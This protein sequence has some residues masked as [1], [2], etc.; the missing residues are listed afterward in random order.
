MIYIISGSK[1]YADEF[2]YP[3]LSVFDED[4]MKEYTTLWEKVQDTRKDLNESEEWYFGT[5]EGFYWSLNEVNDI[6]QNASTVTEEELNVI[7]K[8]AF[9]GY[10]V[11]ER[12]L[13]VL[14]DLVDE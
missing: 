6:I 8:Y 1:D 7:E 3:L 9:M 5:N 13:D 4:E 11:F 12:A 14:T 2:N 10:D